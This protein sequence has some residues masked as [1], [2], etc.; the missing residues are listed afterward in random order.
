MALS[1]APKLTMEFIMTNPVVTT[2]IILSVIVAVAV[3]I[4]VPVLH[5][6][7]LQTK[8]KDDDD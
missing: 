7:D 5:W 8:R 6:L 4:L 2:A 1:G 3:A